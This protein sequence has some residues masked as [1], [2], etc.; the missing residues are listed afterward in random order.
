MYDDGVTLTKEDVTDETGS[1]V[2]ENLVK[3]G[4]AEIYVQELEAINGYELDTK[5]RKV[6]VN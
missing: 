6:V 1:F 4:K 3:S 5:E 2:F